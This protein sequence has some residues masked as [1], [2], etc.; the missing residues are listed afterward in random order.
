MRALYVYDCVRVYDVLL[1][2]IFTLC[3]IRT[4]DM[5]NFSYSGIVEPSK[6]AAEIMDLSGDEVLHW[7]F[8]TSS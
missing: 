7:G 1:F 4:P 2:S 5:Y 6:A 8:V 3:R